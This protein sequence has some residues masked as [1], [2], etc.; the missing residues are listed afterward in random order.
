MSSHSASVELAAHLAVL[1]SISFGGS[2]RFS[3]M[4]ITSSLRMVGLPTRSSPFFRGR[5][6]DAGDRTCATVP[7]VWTASGEE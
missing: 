3:R 7:V 1:S 6:G 4:S 5:A 2:R